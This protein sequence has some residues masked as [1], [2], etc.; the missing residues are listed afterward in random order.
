M[1]QKKDQL[2]FSHKIKKGVQIKVMESSCKIS[3]VP[4]EV[5]EK[6]KVF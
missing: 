3:R 1:E 2:V 5:I 4:K 6:A